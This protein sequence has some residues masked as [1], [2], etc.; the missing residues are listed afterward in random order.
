MRES[1]SASCS[2][3]ESE[4]ACASN[5]ETSGSSVPSQP[6]TAYSSF[7][8]AI[9]FSGGP[10]SAFSLNP[11]ERAYPEPG[12]RNREAYGKQ[13]PPRSGGVARLVLPILA[14]T[15]HHSDRGNRQEG[16]SGHLQPELV[17]HPPVRMCGR[18][19]A[20]QHRSAR[21][22]ALHHVD[23]RT[24]NQLDFFHGFLSIIM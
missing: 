2:S 7:F 4:S 12:K 11:P 1:A 10:L 19:D 22:A 8:P 13:Q 9:L 3:T 5:L 21:P 14:Q 20:R 17:Q 6:H 24:I 23:D 18:T 16:E 15:G